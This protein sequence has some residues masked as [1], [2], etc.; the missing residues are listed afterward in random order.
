MPFALESIHTPEAS[1]I[2][3]CNNSIQ[4]TSTTRPTDDWAD[5]C[6]W[7]SDRY[8]EYLAEQVRHGARHGALE[9][10]ARN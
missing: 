1:K 2:H 9:A 5:G 3:L 4:K 7:S 10:E 8:Q 6:M